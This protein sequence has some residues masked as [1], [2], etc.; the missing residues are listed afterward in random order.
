MTAGF[1]LIV[2]WVGV[3]GFIVV[4]VKDGGVWLAGGITAI[5]VLWM[6]ADVS[7]ALCCR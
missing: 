7:W 4:K 1:L 5:L 3:L 2:L 6:I